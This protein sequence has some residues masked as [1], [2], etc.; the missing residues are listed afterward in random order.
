MKLPPLRALRAFESA[1]RTGS[2][3][4]AADELGVT[5]AAVS[6]QVRNLETYY[7]RQLFTRYNNRIVLTDAGSKIFANLAPALHDLAQKNREL[8]DGPTAARLVVSVLPSLAQAW[9]VPRLARFSAQNPNIGIH[10]RVEEDPVD[11]TRLGIDLRIT[12]GNQLYSD[13]AAQPLFRD[14]VQPMCSHDFAVRFPDATGDLAQLRAIRCW[15]TVNRY[16]CRVS[17]WNSRAPVSASSSDSGSSPNPGCAT[18][19]CWRCRRTRCRS[20]RVTLRFTRTVVTNPPCSMRC[21]ARSARPPNPGP[22]DRGR[23]PPQ[24][25]RRQRTPTGR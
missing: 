12:Y 14:A 18:V 23:D 10:T 22:P 17:G 4:D 15:R 16:P 25:T 7:S 9:L 5:A 2:Y 8:L 24:P 3:V 1:A 6:Q 13:F 11:L 21:C 20:A 19:D